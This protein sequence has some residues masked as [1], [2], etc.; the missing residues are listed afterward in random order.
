MSQAQYRLEVAIHQKLLTKE[1]I[2]LRSNIEDKGN[3]EGAGET[4]SSDGRS[5]S[6]GKYSPG[7]AKKKKTGLYKWKVRRKKPHES[8]FVDSANV[9]GKS[10][11]FWLD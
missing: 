10:C 11:L 5:W 3:P 6:Q 7:I 8:L 9:E 2:N 4:Y 1:G